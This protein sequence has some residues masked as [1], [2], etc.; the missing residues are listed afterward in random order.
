MIRLVACIESTSDI[1]VG[2]GANHRA[3]RILTFVIAVA[4]FVAIGLALH[5]VAGLPAWAA[6]AIPAAVLGGVRGLVQR[7]P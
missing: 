4:V 1:V 5:Y 6:V 7:S 3:G 2:V